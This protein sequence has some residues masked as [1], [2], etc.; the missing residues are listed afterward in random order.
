MRLD[1]VASALPWRQFQRKLQTVTEDAELAAALKTL[2]AFIRDGTSIPFPAR[3][4]H[5][6]HPTRASLC[7]PP[8]FAALHVQRCRS[9]L[10]GV[11][12]VPARRW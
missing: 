5:A 1:F 3:P 6:P 4:S 9:L 8:R 7:P 12:S 10:G 11:G 2:L